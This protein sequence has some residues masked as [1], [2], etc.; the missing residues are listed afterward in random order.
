MYTLFFNCLIG[1]NHFPPGVLEMD[2]P[3]NYIMTLP[4]EDP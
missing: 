1:G 3:L 4:E 2:S